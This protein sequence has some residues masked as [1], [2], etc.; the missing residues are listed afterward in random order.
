M[1]FLSL[2]SKIVK[3]GPA[4][5]ASSEQG[6][7]SKVWTMLNFFSLFEDISQNSL[8]SGISS[9]FGRLKLSYSL[10]LSNDIRLSGFSSTIVQL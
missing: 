3:N 2:C 9:T 7:S 4:L 8:S 5:G 10:L 1:N 6:V